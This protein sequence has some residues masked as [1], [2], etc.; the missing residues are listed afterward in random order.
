MANNQ[1]VQSATPVSI[2]QIIE[3]LRLQRHACIKELLQD[4]N[5][6]SFLE[7]QYDV[8]QISSVRREFLKRD[9]LEL[10]DSSLDRVHYASLIKDIKE[11]GSVELQQHPLFLSELRE[12]FKKYYF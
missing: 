10:K 9:L 2:E 1:P 5:L 7:A 3:D 11:N 8:F 12:I 6:M 4:S